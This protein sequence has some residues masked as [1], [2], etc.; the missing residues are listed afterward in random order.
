MPEKGRWKVTW[1]V[2]ITGCRKPRKVPNLEMGSKTWCYFYLP[3]V[4]RIEQPVEWCPKVI[5]GTD[6]L[7]LLRS[8]KSLDFQCLN[9]I[10]NMP[11]DSN[12]TDLLRSLFWGN[13]FVGC[14]LMEQPPKYLIILGQGI[15][16]SH[17]RSS[18]AAQF[19]AGDKI[20]V[21]FSSWNIWYFKKEDSVIYFPLCPPQWMVLL[22]CCWQMGCGSF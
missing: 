20:H 18:S 11:R 3:A 19:G 21:A 1:T 2:F 4:L 8:T 17:H 10:E 12:C 9:S 13:F 22:M 5:S 14:S 6:V 16:L 7:M 15:A